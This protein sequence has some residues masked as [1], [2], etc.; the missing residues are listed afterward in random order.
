M[1]NVLQWAGE[2]PALLATKT[3]VLLQQRLLA[4]ATTAAYQEYF[5]V[6]AL[7][8]V[9]GILPALPWEKLFPL[10]E[11]DQAGASTTDAARTPSPS[12]EK[13]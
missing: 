10:S 5:F 1:H 8:G 2:I 7:V 3:S 4:E 13:T 6:A 9:L 11:P 12:Y